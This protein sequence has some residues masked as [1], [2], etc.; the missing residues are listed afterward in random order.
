[1]QSNDKPCRHEYIKIFQRK[2]KDFGRRML[3][4]RGYLPTGFSSKD[5]SFLPLGAY[6]FCT[7]CRQRL[8]PTRPVKIA[9]TPSSQPVVNIPSADPTDTI[10]TEESTIASPASTQ[11]IDV[12]ELQIE[13]IEVSDL[14]DKSI[15]VNVSEEV[16]EEEGEE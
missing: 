13:P 4:T 2:Y 7:N 14:L 10:W 3:S 15:S 12:E 6:C 8:F 16:E 9:T 1:M 5:F 11:E